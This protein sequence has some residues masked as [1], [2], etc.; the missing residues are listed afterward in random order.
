MMNRLYFIIFL[1]NK[2]Y[3]N[4]FGLTVNLALH[5]IYNLFNNKD[6]S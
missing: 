4:K 3:N 1:Y 5:G 6:D 2:I